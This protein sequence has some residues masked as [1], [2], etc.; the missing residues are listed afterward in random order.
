MKRLSGSE[1]S[2]E[3]LQGFLDIIQEYREQHHSKDS[4][5]VFQDPFP[6]LNTNDL[7]IANVS[8][9]QLSGNE[10]EQLTNVSME[11]VIADS[12]LFCEPSGDWCFPD[13]LQSTFE[14]TDEYM[15]EA[16]PCESPGDLLG[17]I[18]TAAE[19][20]LYVPGHWT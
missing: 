5:K 8:V 19:G 15:S 17:D 9:P 3:R 4:T 12:Q 11:G 6:A 20:C 18:S 2:L 13:G 1:T 10:T 14:V 16:F 7:N